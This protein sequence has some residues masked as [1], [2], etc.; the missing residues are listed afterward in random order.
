[1]TAPPCDPCDGSGWLWWDTGRGWA[2]CATGNDDEATPT[3]AVV[4]GTV[5]QRN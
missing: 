1:M 5:E 4:A 2:A 3:P